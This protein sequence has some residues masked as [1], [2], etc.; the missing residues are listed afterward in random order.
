MDSLTKEKRA[1]WT[2]NVSGY[3]SFQHFGTEAEA[4]DQRSHKAA[5]EGGRGRKQ[6][7]TEKE[8]K[9]GT[10]HLRWQRDHG[11]NL[12]DWELEAIK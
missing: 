8:I 3:G 11:Y 9:E 1:W 10:A 4:E 2:I 7:S 12:E 5:W 6:L